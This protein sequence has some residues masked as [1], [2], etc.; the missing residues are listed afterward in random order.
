[1]ARFNWED[2]ARLDYVAKHGSVPFWVGLGP[3]EDA[4]EEREVALRARLQATLDVVRDYATLSP[5]E[6]QRMYEPLHRRLCARFDDERWRVRHEDKGLLHAID[7][8]EA[9][10][11]SL[12]AG[13]RP[14]P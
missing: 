9:G 8:Y 14:R 3:G 1:M 4:A 11:L 13:L 5:V 12:L 10:V 7:E 2:A 6:E